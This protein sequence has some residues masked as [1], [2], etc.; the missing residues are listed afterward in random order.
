MEEM[1]SMHALEKLRADKEPKKKFREPRW[2]ESGSQAARTTFNIIEIDDDDL[3]FL[4][5]PT[6]V[7][8]IG[9]QSRPDFGGPNRR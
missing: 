2:L 6:H 9:K 8:G 3:R 1:E 4:M 7:C 5:F